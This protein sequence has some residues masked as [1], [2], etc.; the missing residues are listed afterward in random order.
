[1]FTYQCTIREARNIY[2][3]GL[4]AKQV[5]NPRILVKNVNSVVGPP[6]PQTNLK[7]FLNRLLKKTVAIRQHLT[8]ISEKW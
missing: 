6:P 3:S 8:L 2:F 5:H 1:M 7:K 4:I